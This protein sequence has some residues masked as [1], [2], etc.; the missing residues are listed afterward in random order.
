VDPLL[1]VLPAD[2]VIADN[3]AFARAVEIA[4]RAASAGKLVAFGVEPDRPETGYGYILR[5]KQRGAW[6]EIERFVEKPDVKRAEEYVASGKYWWNSGMFLFSAS[7]L[8]SEIS[9]HAPEILWACDRIVTAARADT[10][11]VTLPIEFERCPANS[12]DYAVMQETSLG[13]AVPLSAGWSAATHWVIRLWV[14]SCL[15]IVRI[16]M[17]TAASD[18]LRQLVW[19]RSSS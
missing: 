10:R 3:A 16:P 13:A 1:L 15:R 4:V 18:L 12:I 5:G 8:L 6:A 14:R 19:K 2:H 17:S 7:Q 11:V 9:E